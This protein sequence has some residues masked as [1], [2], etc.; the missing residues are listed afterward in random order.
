MYVKDAYYLTLARLRS[1]IAESAFV[2]SFA[3]LFFHQK[4]LGSDRTDVSVV[5]VV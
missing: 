3:D 4:R 1:V 5:Y 2:G